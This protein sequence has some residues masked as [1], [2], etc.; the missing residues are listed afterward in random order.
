MTPNN[1]VAL[2]SHGMN[3]STCSM[4]CECGHECKDHDNDASECTKCECEE[5]IDQDPEGDDYDYS[6]QKDFD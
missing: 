4:L 2:C 1:I 5:F 6:T 3:Q